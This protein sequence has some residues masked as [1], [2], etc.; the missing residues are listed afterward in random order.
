MFKDSG[1]AKIPVKAYRT[2]GSEFLVYVTDFTR[3]KWEDIYKE[4]LAIFTVPPNGKIKENLEKLMQ[5]GGFN[6]HYNLV[7][8]F[9]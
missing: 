8:V 4:R 1:K 2:H 5:E 6:E 9:I 3:E 7:E